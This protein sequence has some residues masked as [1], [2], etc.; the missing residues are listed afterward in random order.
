MSL[1]KGFPMANIFLSYS[2][3]DRDYVEQ[4]ERALEE[5][6]QTVTMD[7]GKVP[8]GSSW[9][10]TIREA[11]ENADVFVVIVSQESIGRDFAMDA[12]LG[13]AWGRGKRIV[14]I[15]TSDVSA[16]SSLSL[17][18]AD[19]EVVSANGLSDDELAAAVME[20]SRL[21]ATSPTS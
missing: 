2:A 8:E 14:A 3:H 17:P 1:G 6:G 4:L 16:T 10:D 9:A 11:I 20:K 5:K 18:R 15:E 7:R 21:A 13:A 19:Y 12:E